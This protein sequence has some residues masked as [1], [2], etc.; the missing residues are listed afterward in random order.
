MS[1]CESSPDPK[2]NAK[3]QEELARIT[4]EL[5]VM[6]DEPRIIVPEE[7]LKN[8]DIVNKMK[9]K[10]A[11]LII[12]RN[13]LQGQFSPT[14]RQLIDL[15]VEIAR[16]KLEIVE[17]LKAEKK[18]LD[19]K[20]QTLKARQDEVAR[21]IV[22]VTQKVDSI[23]VLLPQY[24]RLKNDLITAN[25]NYAKVETELLGAQTDEQRARKAVS[26]QIVDEA[27]TPDPEH[28]AI[29]WTPV[30]TAIAAVVSLLLAL[31]YAF[32]ADHFD[33]TL[34]G[35]QDVERYLGATVVGSVAKAGRRI[36]V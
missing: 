11:D 35:I 1:L 23:S 17:E 24:E 33:H 36:V 8:N 4:A 34:R 7:V 10:L 9:K 3:R 27:S 29:P 28:P 32:M 26:V 22:R 12:N 2:E 20:I 5:A 21:Q 15:Y 14:F 6:T 31:A 18:A 30:Y 19:V 16:A 13:R 25:T